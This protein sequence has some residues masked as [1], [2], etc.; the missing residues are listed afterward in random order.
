MNIQNDGTFTDNE[1]NVLMNKDGIVKI[2]IYEEVEGKKKL[3]DFDKLTVK[4]NGDIYY[5]KK[6]IVE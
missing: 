3:I 4:S 2:N 1:G 5:N 6:L